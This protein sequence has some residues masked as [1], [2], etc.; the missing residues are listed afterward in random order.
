MIANERQY[1]ITKNWLR[2]FQEAR[3]NVE[4]RHDLQPRARRALRD[5]YDSQV[6]ELGAQLAEYESLRRG[7]V[8]MI[9]V[10]SLAALPEALIRARAATGLSQEALAKRLGWKKQQ[11]QRYEATR[12]AG[13]TLERLQAIVDAM[14]V[15]V[16]EQVLLRSDAAGASDRVG[17][18]Q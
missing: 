4:E 8:A 14:G 15:Q 5:Q 6:E 1:R 9:E 10:D 2:R 7:D 16:R 18:E 17:R 13:V 12:Y 3:A 11:L